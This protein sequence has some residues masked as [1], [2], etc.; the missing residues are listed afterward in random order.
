MIKNKEVKLTPYNVGKM[1][2]WHYV[3]IKVK[4]VGIAIYAVDNGLVGSVPKLS[5]FLRFMSDIL[6]FE[7]KGSKN[8]LILH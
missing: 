6:I 1:R 2:T 7:Q 4:L 8:D 5:D 3:K